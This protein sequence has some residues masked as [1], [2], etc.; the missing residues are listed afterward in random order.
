MKSLPMKTLLALFTLAA[1]AHPPLT[2]TEKALLK[3]H[4]R[5]AGIARAQKEIAE[6]ATLRVFARNEN[7]D[8]SDAFRH[9]VGAALLVKELGAP[10]AQ[11][12][13]DA[14]ETGSGNS[15]P[16]EKMDRANNTVAVQD[17]VALQK[18]HP[19]KELSLPEIEAAA[20]RA[21]RE[22]RLEVLAPRGLPTP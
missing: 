15:G 14:H 13:L 4:R 22:K 1:L 20:L 9:Y 2:K 11:K 10:M 8:E 12:F 21:L 5:E 7:R 19:T 16:E 6:K 3:S 18:S 17:T